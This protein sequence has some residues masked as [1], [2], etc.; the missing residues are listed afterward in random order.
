MFI[1]PGTQT[2][3]NCI[4]WSL[5]LSLPLVFRCVIVGI[6]HYFILYTPPS[7]FSRLIKRYVSSFAGGGDL[8]AHGVG[9]RVIHILY[10]YSA[11]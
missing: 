8:A 7:D 6:P 10:F 3:P 5:R 2:S 9:N 4:F 1:Q 11:F